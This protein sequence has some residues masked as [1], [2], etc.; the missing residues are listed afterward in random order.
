[1][2]ITFKKGQKAV[3]HLFIKENR[4]Q[5]GSLFTNASCRD[6]LNKTCGVIEVVALGSSFD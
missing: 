1:M 2:G 4:C 5:V 3:S 6:H